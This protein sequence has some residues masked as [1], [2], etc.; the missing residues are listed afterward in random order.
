MAY[1]LPVVALDGGR[2]GTLTRWRRLGRTG[3]SG[4]GSGWDTH[5]RGASPGRARPARRPGTLKG[6]RGFGLLAGVLSCKSSNLD[7]EGGSSISWQAADRVAG[8]EDRLP[9]MAAFRCPTVL[10]VP[11]RSSC[12]SQGVASHGA[13]ALRQPVMRRPLWSAGLPGRSRSARRSPWGHPAAGGSTGCRPGAHRTRPAGRARA[14]SDRRPA[15]RA[16]RP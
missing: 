14:R 6:M 1:G 12:S 7:H 2:P 8:P 3:T 4:Q 16:A 9:A 11:K 13:T 15:I 5:R 10:P